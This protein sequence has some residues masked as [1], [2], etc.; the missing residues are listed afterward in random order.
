MAASR[1]PTQDWCCHRH[2]AGSSPK[3][4]GPKTVVVSSHVLHEVERFADR[5]LVIV[6]GRL[7][8]AGDYRA[9]R[10]KIDE[11]ARLVQVKA[12]AARELG[13]ALIGHT[14][15]RGLHVKDDALTVETDDIRAIYRLVPRVAHNKGIHLYEIVALDDSLTSVFAYVTERRTS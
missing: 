3:L 2:R 11:R 4:N 15:I 5:I 13:A 7:A 14:E 8:A 12:S 6:A 9:I 1:R 10:D